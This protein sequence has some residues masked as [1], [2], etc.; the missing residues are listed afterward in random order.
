[1]VNLKF[2][3]GWVR[4][5]E[6]GLGVMIIFGALLLFS[7]GEKHSDKE[8]PSSF[9]SNILQEAAKNNTLREKIIRNS[10]DAE[11]ELEKFVEMRLNKKTF[12]YSVRICEPYGECK[13]TESASGDVYSAEYII[14]SSQ[15]LFQP[16]LIK[17][18][19]WRKDS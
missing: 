18:F 5:V 10:A 1:M 16:K 2:R 13:L 14:S 3:K 11:A 7:L 8:D 6:A 19:L 15:S 17:I 4:I 9:L 12:I